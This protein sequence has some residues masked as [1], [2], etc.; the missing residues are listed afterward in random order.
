M[1]KTLFVM[2]GAILLSMQA[3]QAQTPIYREVFGNSGTTNANVNTVGWF[4]N[5]GATATDASIPSPNNFGISSSQGKPNNL[6]NINAGGPALSI[7]N[8]ILFTSGTGASA[9]NWIA[10]QSLYTVNTILTPVQ[11]ISFYLGSAAGAVS[12]VIPGFRVAVQIDNNWYASTAVFANTVSVSSGANFNA[13]AQQFT[14]NWTTAA[15][16]WDNLTFVPGTA[17][18]LG[19]TLTSPLPGDN[20]TAFGVYT[21]AENAGDNATRRIDTYQID[22][23]PEPGSVMLGLFGVGALMGLRRSRKA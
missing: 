15:S 5:Y 7:P 3:T 13:N 17:L 21:D 2:A 1:K 22:T 18:A 9:V 4:G 10:Y 12:G 20:I 11:D 14:F 16:A 23:V 19:S 8:G 6:D